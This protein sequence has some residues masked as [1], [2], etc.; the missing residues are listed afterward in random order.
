MTCYRVNLAFT[1][2]GLD[3][4]LSPAN[5][6]FHTLEPPSYL[7]CHPCN[8]AINLSLPDIAQFVSLFLADAVMAFLYFDGFMLVNLGSC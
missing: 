2:T 7:N 1:F 3:N 8:L 5:G 6:P 4:C